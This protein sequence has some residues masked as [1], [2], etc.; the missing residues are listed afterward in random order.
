M[1][2]VFGTLTDFVAKFRK[3]LLTEISKITYAHHVTHSGIACWISSSSDWITR[4]LS[5]DNAW[6]LHSINEVKRGTARLPSQG[7][8]V[9][10]WKL[11]DAPRSFGA[12]DK[13]YACRPKRI[14]RFSDY[15][16]CKRRFLKRCVLQH[17]PV[18][19]P[20]VIAIQFKWDKRTSCYRQSDKRRQN[21]RFLSD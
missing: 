3:K 16:L 17:K 14:S 21:K 15:L 5:L 4:R 20:G 11:R 8:G 13:S 9:A 19:Q 12:T 18:E 7:A 1:R 10:K 2:A 6:R